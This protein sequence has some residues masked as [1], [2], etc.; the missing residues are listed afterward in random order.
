[1]GRITLN[2]LHTVP[3]A[4]DNF[5]KVWS[6]VQYNLQGIS[7]GD[8]QWCWSLSSSRSMQHLHYVKTRPSRLEQWDLDTAHC[9]FHF[10]LD[11]NANFIFQLIFWGKIASESS[12]CGSHF[13][14]I[15]THMCT[16]TSCQQM[17]KRVQ[18]NCSHS[19]NQALIVYKQVVLTQQ[20]PVNGTKAVCTEPKSAQWYVRPPLS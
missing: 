8:I 3:H 14:L 13:L 20:Y 4:C 6:N 15:R 2:H 17:L 16:S 12:N 10:T 7:E 18:F 11:S 5:E 9:V 1:M 19:T